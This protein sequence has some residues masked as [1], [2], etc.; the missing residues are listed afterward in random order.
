[1]A[2]R[3]DR[4]LR[5]KRALLLNLDE[6]LEEGPKGFTVA[7]VDPAYAMQ[8]ALE[9]EYTGIIV[10]PG[11][12]EKYA[13]ERF[14]DLPIVIKLNGR[15]GLPSMDPS[16]RLLCTVE[17]AIKLGAEAVAFVL[18]DGSPSDPERFRDFGL[19]VEQAHDYGIPVLAIIGSRHA[20]SPDN[21]AYAARIALELG[22]DAIQIAYDG[23][24][25]AFEWVVQ[26]A[27]RASVF[28]SEQGTDHEALKRAQ[29][30]MLAGAHGLSLGKGVWQHHK[31][32]SLTRALHAV[33]FNG[34]TPED[35]QK[36][37]S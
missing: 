23:D 25:H 27:G 12:A 29:Q 1:M 5:E 35:A 34:K 13:T 24:Q 36:Y 18:A 32:F 17:R 2:S 21:D 14:R 10:H 19:V 11:I 6:G 30:V 37:L 31:P 20:R 16:G 33:V 26:C 7:T 9:G 15:S 3:I 28:V 22:A 4:I 8:I